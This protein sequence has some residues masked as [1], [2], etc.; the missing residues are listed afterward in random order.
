MEGKKLCDLGGRGCTSSWGVQ[1]AEKSLWRVA[2]GFS[3]AALVSERSLGSS[4]AA[5]RSPLACSEPTVA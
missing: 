3:P 2:G 5:R 1:R 4:L